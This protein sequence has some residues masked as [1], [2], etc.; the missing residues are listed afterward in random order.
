MT[1]I[2]KFTQMFLVMIIL[3]VCYTIIELFHTIP[4]NTLRLKHD[5]FIELKS[6]LEVKKSIPVQLR[7]QGIDTPEWL[8]SLF[9]KVGSTISTPIPGYFEIKDNISL[10]ELLSRIITNKS[11]KYKVL[12][13]EGYSLRQIRNI[14][15]ENKYLIHKTSNLTNDELAQMIGSN[16]FNL[17]GLFFPST[18]IFNPDTDDVNIYKQALA[19]MEKNLNGV[20]ASRDTGVH[21]KNSYE[22]LI[23]ASIIEKET[24]TQDSPFIISSVFH[25]RLKKNMRLQSD[26]T[27]IYG[28]GEKFDGNLRKKDLSSRSPYNTY[29][30]NGLPPTPIASPGLKSLKAA[31]NPDKTTYL[32]FVSN[33]NGK[34]I[35]SSDLDEHNRAV[36]KFQKNSSIK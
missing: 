21:L 14:V 3:F 36:H 35:F 11:T 18:Y 15:N 5:K 26:P 6:I 34:S 32:Y 2:I 33:G 7:N 17:E 22:G 1:R 27:V 20:W 29:T 19:L 28:L 23:L 8:L 24:G 31:M 10:F 4:V 13:P 25:N 16:N 9:I 12:F 30:T